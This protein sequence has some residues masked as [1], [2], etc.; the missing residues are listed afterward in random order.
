MKEVI[1]L[2]FCFVFGAEAWPQKK[3]IIEEAEIVVDVVESWSSN[4]LI[5]VGLGLG[6]LAL[7]LW[8]IDRFTRPKFY[9]LK[10]KHVV[11]TGGS[12][13]IGKALALRVAGQGADVTLMARNKEALQAAQAEIISQSGK[14]T[15]QKVEIESVDLAENFEKVQASIESAVKKIG[16]PVDV[17]INCAGMSVPGTFEDVD[18]AVFEHLMRVNYLGSVY[19]TRAVVPSMKRQ[20]CGRIVFVSSQAGQLGV[21]GFS[22]Y[23]P[24]KFAIVGLAQVLSMEL[25]P[26]DIHVTVAYPPDTDTPGFK[27]ENKGKPEET[28]L[29]SETSGL[30]QP[31]QVA[32]DIVSGL[33]RGAFTAYTG[34]DGWLLAHLTAGMGP[35]S[36]LFEGI[37]QVAYMSLFRFISFFFL[38]SFDQI[39]RKCK[40]RRDV[41]A[42]ND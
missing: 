16:K 13:G 9:D 39:I 37:A 7:L 15:G 1:L 17:L 19:P 27:E 34:L 24:T 3:G 23:S 40:Q 11:I 32:A 42:K 30:F 10:G 12:K 18:I 38:A 6:V 21:F 4:R 5:L 33:Q 36:S 8:V 2:S 25:K 26:Y 31:D 28:C 20:G 22:A 29:I 14:N 41:K 35:C